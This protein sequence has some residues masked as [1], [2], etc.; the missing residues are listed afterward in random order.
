M[1]FRREQVHLTRSH[2]EESWA[3]SRAAVP[4]SGACPDSLP[5]LTPEA[6]RQMTAF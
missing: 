6:L 2:L 5:L 4:F 1:T 3:T